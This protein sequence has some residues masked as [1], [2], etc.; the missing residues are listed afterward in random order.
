MDQC[1]VD[2]LGTSPLVKQEPYLAVKAACCVATRVPSIILH[3]FVCIFH[4]PLI[5]SIICALH[6]AIYEGSGQKSVG[7]TV[8]VHCHKGH[9]V[10]N[11][12]GDGRY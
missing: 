6:F 7:T 2:S 4:S 9:L 10:V 3:V 5:L 11:I 12:N 8:R 1:T